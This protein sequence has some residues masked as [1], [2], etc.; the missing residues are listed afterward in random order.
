[1]VFGLIETYLWLSGIKKLKAS[2]IKAFNKIPSFQTPYPGVPPQNPGYIY[3][4][5]VSIEFQAKGVVGEL[6]SDET[7]KK[8]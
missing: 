7:I 1:M 3:Q 2:Y 8:R 4:T 6:P 5:T